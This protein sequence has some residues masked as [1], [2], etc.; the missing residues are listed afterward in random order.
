MKCCWGSLRQCVLRLCI[1]KQLLNYIMLLGNL[2]N[3]NVSFVSKMKP[4]GP[5]N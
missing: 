4:V 2:R 5:K 1:T 3:C